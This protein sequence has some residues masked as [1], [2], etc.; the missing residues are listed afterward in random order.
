MQSR[1]LAVLQGLERHSLM[2]PSHRSPVKPGGQLQR[3]PPTRSTQEQRKDSRASWQTPALRQ[4]CESH[5]LTSYWQWEPVKP[6][7]QLHE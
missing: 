5:S 2:S 7:R 3:Y 1:L 4:G 6:E